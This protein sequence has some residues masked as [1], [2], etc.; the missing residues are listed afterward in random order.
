MTQTARAAVLAGPKTI[1][2]R[3][4]PLPAIGADDALLR[5]EACGICGTDYEQYH[6]EVPPHAYYTP[7]PVI[8]G[9]E[10]LGVIA[11]IGERARARWGV[12]VGDRVA[13][14]SGY[15]CGKCAACA[16]F[17]PR[18]CQTRGGT[19]GFTDVRTSPA[20]WGGYAEYMY[21]CPLSVVRRVDPS[22]PAEVAVM[23]NPLAAGLSWA[24]SVPQTRPGERV[25]VLG[26]GQRGLCAVIAAREAGAAQ[27][28][29]TGL[30]RDAHKLALARDLG[31]TLT[32][33][34]EREDVVAAVTEA[35]GGGADVVVDTTPLAPRSLSH[36]VAMARTRGRIV[37]A[38]LKGRRPTPDLYADDVIYKQLTIH[39]VLS[40]PY[41]DFER[42][43]RLIESRK[44]PLERLHTHSFPIEQA[45]L[46]IQTLAGGVPGANP[47]HIAIAPG[48]PPVRLAAEEGGHG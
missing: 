33:D 18:A 13:V 9:H 47:V 21:L 46:A 41:D 36:A 30:T 7:F 48:A 1:E 10:P 11:E 39:G 34:A 44:Y 4:F 40:M 35:T 14:R 26:P 20:L 17:E 24:W 3:D 6:G 42:A 31:A 27:I 15:G 45:E 16:R 22:L 43:V 32:V 19:Y 5:I 38:G 12:T 2:L 37:L 23:F 28:I 29:V 25:A 8:P